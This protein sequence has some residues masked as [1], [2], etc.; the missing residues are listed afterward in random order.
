M[1]LSPDIIFH[2]KMHSKQIALKNSIE[3]LL[4][5]AKRKQRGK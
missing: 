1:L 4:A 5:E 2:A 3:V